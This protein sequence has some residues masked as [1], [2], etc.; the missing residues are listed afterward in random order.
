MILKR[1]Q[2]AMEFLMTYGW[3]ILVALAAI[4]TLAYFGVMN[5]EKNLPEKCVFPSG[6]S[7]IGFSYNNGNIEIAMINNMAY[8]MTN[9]N[10]TAEGCQASSTGPET[11]KND[12]QGT[13]RIQCDL[14]GQE[15][16]KKEINIRYTNKE[17]SLEH[18]KKGQI[19]MKIAQN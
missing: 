18:E 14:S 9:I 12:E 11:L 16:I 19:I 4:G 2:A 8:T 5:P 1:G 10:L 6:I 15:K 7:C 13:Y 3:T 17:S